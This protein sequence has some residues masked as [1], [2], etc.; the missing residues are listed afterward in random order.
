MLCGDSIAHSM[1]G[2]Q[3]QENAKKMVNICKQEKRALLAHICSLLC[4]KIIGTWTK[5]DF[6]FH[7]KFDN[8]DMHNLYRS[9]SLLIEMQHICATVESCT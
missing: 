9:K 7:Q 2:T 5:E 1:C 8:L 3:R 4:S 6:V